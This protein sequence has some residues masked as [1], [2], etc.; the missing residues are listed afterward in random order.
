MHGLYFLQKC[1]TSNFSQNLL[2]N[3]YAYLPTDSRFICKSIKVY[4]IFCVGRNGYLWN[5][6][7]S[8]LILFHFWLLQR[9]WSLFYCRETRKGWFMSLG[10]DTPFLKWVSFDLKLLVS[11]KYSFCN[12][13]YM[14]L[15]NLGSQ[16]NL[17]Q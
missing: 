9:N 10:S 13:A 11:L 6:L 14:T 5:S 7:H 2:L 16:R 12:T 17:Y 4:P 15:K 8:L 1:A 3:F